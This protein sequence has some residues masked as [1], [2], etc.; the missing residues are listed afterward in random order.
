MLPG[1]GS[2]FFFFFFRHFYTGKNPCRNTIIPA[3]CVFTGV[4][5]TVPWAPLLMCVPSAAEGFQHYFSSCVLD[6]IRKET[7]L[8][9]HQET[10]PRDYFLDALTRAGLKLYLQFGWKIFFKFKNISSKHLMYFWKYNHSITVFMACTWG[11]CKDRK[12][13]ISTRD[14]LEP[15]QQKIFFCSMFLF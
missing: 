2:S 13:E 6:I 12:W 4:L 8:S 7:L 1:C 5:Y 11:T 9:I 10:T 14:C 3:K 15:E